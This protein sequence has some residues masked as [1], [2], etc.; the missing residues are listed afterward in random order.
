MTIKLLLLLQ[1]GGAKTSAVNEEQLLNAEQNVCCRDETNHTRELR[2]HAD[3]KVYVIFHPCSLL[4]TIS[5]W[6]KLMLRLLTNMDNYSP[7]VNQYTSTVNSQMNILIKI[8]DCHQKLT[9]P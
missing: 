5:S 6:L 9:V 4:Y 2:D 3:G 7:L 1:P 8:P